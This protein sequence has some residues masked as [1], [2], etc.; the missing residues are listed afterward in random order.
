MISKPAGM[1][2]V[3]GGW[4]DSST[5]DVGTSGNY[6][7][8]LFKDSIFTPTIRAIITTL[9]QM[10]KE[11]ATSFNYDE[12]FLAASTIMMALIVVIGI[13]LYKRRQNPEN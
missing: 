6:L 5:S 12:M 10:N 8:T 2:D 11:M 3:K 9:D 13:I 1:F 7:T 4:W